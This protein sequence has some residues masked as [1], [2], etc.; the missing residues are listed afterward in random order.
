MGFRRAVRELRL[1]LKSIQGGSSMG[2]RTQRLK[3]K[4]N[5]AVGKTKVAAGRKAGDRKTETKGTTQKLKGK[6]QN[7][8]GK[9]RG[10]A[11]KTAR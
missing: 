8:V 3:G 7:T 2:D 1:A 9:V 4:T 6:A 10:A 5:E 11:K